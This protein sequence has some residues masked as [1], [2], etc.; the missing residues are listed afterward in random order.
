M[1]ELRLPR[2]RCSVNLNANVT[3]PLR[4]NQTQRRCC[5]RRSRLGWFAGLRKL[6]KAAADVKLYAA[7]ECDQFPIALRLFSCSSK[8]TW[9]VCPMETSRAAKTSSL[10]SKNFSNFH[11][12]RRRRRRFCCT[13]TDVCR[14]STA[15]TAATA[16]RR[17]MTPA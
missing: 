10:C 9:F 4:R 5:I 3:T 2:K 14:N 16:Y 8:M 6:A 17:R 15:T 1:F 7:I 13:G 12:H 11:H